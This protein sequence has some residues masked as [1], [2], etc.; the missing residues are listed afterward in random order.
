MMRD[1]WFKGSDL[2]SSD[3]SPRRQL[4][5]QVR[6]WALIALG[7]V[8]R[9]VPV[10]QYVTPDEPAWVYR[11]IRFADAVTAHDWA[12]IPVPGHPGVTTMWLGLVGVTVR[13]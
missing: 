6:F 7:L 13:R 4:L 2:P 5:P 11:S 9:V 12:A 10:N 1:L 8:L 3:P